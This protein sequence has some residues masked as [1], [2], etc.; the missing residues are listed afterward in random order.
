MEVNMK[1]LLVALVLVI[2]IV[3]NSSALLGL[4]S[5]PTQGY[6]IDY[7]IM[8]KIFTGQEVKILP[9]EFKINTDADDSI[10][11][12]FS[13]TNERLKLA[14][15]KVDSVINST[16][17]MGNSYITQTAL[18]GSSDVKVVD[19]ELSIPENY[20][21]EYFR[22]MY[23][24]LEGSVVI[25]DTKGE[26]VASTNVPKAF[27][28]NG[29]SVPVSFAIEENKLSLKLGQDERTIFPLTVQ[30]NFVMAP[31]A[32]NFYT[33]FQSYGWITRYD[34]ISLSLTL[35]SQAANWNPGASTASD[36]L[37]WNEVVAEAS[38]T[39]NWSNEAAL[40]EQFLCHAAGMSTEWKD[41]WNLEPWRPVVGFAACVLARCNP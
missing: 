8:D 13:S 32:S 36:T 21:I 10:L 2:S 12:K 15:L 3:A 17:Q 41:P 24:K 7:S 1:R 35:G 11:F 25:L 4:P 19:Y 34:G 6:P 38:W 22:D 29:N 39:S 23:D 37:V 5:D 26:L 27:D 9:D 16:K 31:R 40:K 30:Y 28:S 18:I 14:P 33:F 20:R